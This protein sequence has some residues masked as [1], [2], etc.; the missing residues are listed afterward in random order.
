MRMSH[1]IGDVNNFAFVEKHF[2]RGF[3]AIGIHLRDHGSVLRGTPII[4]RF[5]LLGLIALSARRTLNDWRTIVSERR[6]IGIGWIN[7]PILAAMSVMLRSI[8]LAGSLT[9]YFK[10]RDI[11]YAVRGSA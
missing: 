11:A 2:Q 3:D 7:I 6:Q 5:G 1:G 9:A 4:R 10:R 8:E